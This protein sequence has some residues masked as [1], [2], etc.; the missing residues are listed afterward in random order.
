[1]EGFENALMGLIPERQGV[2]DHLLTGR[3]Q[4][5]DAYSP[6]T[7][8]AIEP[9][10]ARRHQWSEVA[11]ERGAVQ[12]QNVRKRVHASALPA[13]EGDR[14]QPSELRRM[15]AERPKRLVVE[16]SDQPGDPARPE[17]QT[18]HG[19]LLGSIQK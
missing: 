19:H 1:S 16:P 3:R 18:V 11:R 6:I 4:Y 7:R 8:R 2:R 15:Q 14:I 12:R 5:R 9:D 13:A 10:E 17:A